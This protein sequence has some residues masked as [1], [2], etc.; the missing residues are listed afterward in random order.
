MARLTSLLSFI[1]LAFQNHLFTEGR[2]LPPNQYQMQTIANVSVIN[3]P[4]I[5]AAQAYSQEHSLPTVY[6]HMMRSWLLS[7]IV[8]NANETLRN[9]IDLEVHALASILHD[10]GVD[11]TPHS[12]IVSADRRFEVDG[13]FAA[14]SFVES[15]GLARDWDEQRLQL[16]WDSIALHATF[17]I[18]NYKQLEVQLVSLGAVTDFTGPSGVITGQDFKNLWAEFPLGEFPSSFNNSII[19]LCLNKPNTTYDNWVQ[20]FGDRYL[21]DSYHSKGHDLVDLPTFSYVDDI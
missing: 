13:A 8:I 12:D 21:P 3:T 16:V 6:N 2:S 7:A 9:S 5:K 14:R 4:L 19:S 1:L 11:P 17:T 18:A 20:G 10:V 15:H